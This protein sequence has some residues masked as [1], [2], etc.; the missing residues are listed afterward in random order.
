MGNKIEKMKFNMFIVKNF[1]FVL[2]VY[3]VYEIEFNFVYLYVVFGS[4]WLRV[5]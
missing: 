5:M 1:F 3:F 4:Y 2:N